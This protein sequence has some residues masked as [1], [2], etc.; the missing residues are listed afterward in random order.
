MEATR[1]LGPPRFPHAPWNEKSALYEAPEP[2]GLPPSMPNIGSG[3]P[4]EWRHSDFPPLQDLLATLRL[5]AGYSVIVYNHCQGKAIQTNG[6]LTDHRNSI[7]HRLLSLPAYPYEQCGKGIYKFYEITRLAAQMYS[8]LCI[9]PYPPGPAPFADLATR[10]RRE[11]SGLDQRTLTYEESKLLLWILAMGAIM[12]VGTFDRLSFIAATSP[13]ARRLQLESWQDLK[14]V[15][16]T[17]L[18]LDMTNDIDGRDIWNEV[19]FQHHEH[20]ESMTSGSPTPRST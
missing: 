7:Q 10:L 12:T 2:E 15:L 14:S 3:F 8:V 4:E 20:S 5:M 17:F 16:I 6:L 18:W 1:I 19:S 9:Y 13:I 11:L